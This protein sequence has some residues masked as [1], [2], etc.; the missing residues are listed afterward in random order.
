[1]LCG[2][3]ISGFSLCAQLPAVAEAC[4]YA[5]LRKQEATQEGMHAAAELKL[6][7]V[8][9]ILGCSQLNRQRLIA[10]GCLPALSCTMKASVNVCTACEIGVYALGMVTSEQ[11]C[12]REKTCTLYQNHCIHVVTAGLYRCVR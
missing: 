7:E 11:P 5:V 3:A 6:L 4:A 9:Q 12:A 8:F 10:L 2:P 1:M